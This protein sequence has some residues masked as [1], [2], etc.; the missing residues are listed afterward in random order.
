A[1]VREAFSGEGGLHVGGRW[2][3]VGIPVVYTSGS[4]ALAA[5]EKLVHLSGH[6][7]RD[8]YI[9]CEAEISEA[10]IE[11]LSEL[12]SEWNAFPSAAK[13]QRIGD[14]WMKSGRSL[15]LKVPSAIIPVE[16]NFLLN[17]RLIEW[18][19]FVCRVPL[20]FAFD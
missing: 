16:Y 12:P 14:T 17:P 18:E 2:N 11:L 5:L 4:L 7:V 1:T 9:F 20:P 10:D 13:T 3:S 8:E 6:G 15:A 19:K